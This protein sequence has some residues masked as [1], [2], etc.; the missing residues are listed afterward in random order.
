MVEVKEPKGW[1]AIDVNED[2]VTAVSSNGEIK[3]YNLSSL[4]RRTTAT[5]GEGKIQQKYTKDRCVLK[6]ALAKLSRN[7]R[8]LVGSELH[9]GNSMIQRFA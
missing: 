3:I 9:E 7:H 1:I 8:N 2:N 6:K 5:S 4:K